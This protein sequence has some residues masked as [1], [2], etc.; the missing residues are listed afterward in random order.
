MFVLGCRVEQRL[1]GSLRW[2]GW[3]ARLIWAFCAH[4]QQ[5]CTGNHEVEVDHDPDRDQAK[6]KA[7]T[8]D[9]KRRSCHL[10]EVADGRAQAA[11]DAKSRVV[12]GGTVSYAGTSRR[13]T[14]PRQLRR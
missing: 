6:P 9:E 14:S 3:R 5:P 2:R 7:V 1:I 12:S 8:P 4:E 13:R 11:V 10:D